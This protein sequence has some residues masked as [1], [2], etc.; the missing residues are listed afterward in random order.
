MVHTRKSSDRPPNILLFMTDQQ[1][2]DSLGCYGAQWVKTPYLDQLAREG[3]LFETCYTNNPVCTPARA[4]L[5][6]GKELPDHGVYRLHDVLPREETLFPAKLRELGYRTAL[7][8]KLHV[9]GRLEEAAHRHPRDGFDV[10]EW[11]LEPA[12]DID[13]PFNSYTRWL[14]ETHPQFLNHLRSKRRHRGNDPLE[15]TM[16]HWAADRTIDFI[17]SAERGTPFFCMM[18]V[19]D[20]HNPYDNYPLEVEKMIDLGKIP[21]PIPCTDEQPVPYAIL[22]EREH[23]YLGRIATFTKE[24]IQRIRLGYYS[25]IAH[26]D[27]EVGRVLSALEQRGF[28]EDTLI[29]FTS[30]HGDMLGDHDTLVKGAM[31]YDPCTRVPLILRYPRGFGGGTRISSPV[32]LHDL[33]ATILAVGGVNDSDLAVEMPDAKNLLTLCRGE[34]REAHEYLVCPYRNSGINDRGMYWDPPLHSTMV[35]WGRYKLHVY[36][37]VAGWQEDT[38][39]RLYDMEKDPQEMRDLS[40]LPAYRGILEGMKSRL[41]SWFLKFELRNAGKGGEAMPSKDQLIVN[42]IK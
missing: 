41:F 30:D 34:Y 19:F 23:S 3:V 33:A 5:M 24:D 36:H 42:E 17:S 32:Q 37:P 21:P 38:L 6:T 35:R 22:A 29:I 26:F 10:Y 27:L 13:S 16:N 7:F 39:Y 12:V 25:M 2:F 14:G 4:S 28:A 1:R 15:V 20:P 40:A 11:C 31:L 9:S 18:S 8:G